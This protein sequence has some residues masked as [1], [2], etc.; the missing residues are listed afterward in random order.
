MHVTVSSSDC[1]GPW[2]TQSWNYFWMVYADKTSIFSKWT[3][4]L[5]HKQ[6]KSCLAQHLIAYKTA[7]N[8]LFSEMGKN[9]ECCH[10][11]LRHYLCMRF[12]SADSNRMQ[13]CMQQ[14]CFSVS[15][16]INEVFQWVSKAAWEWAP[17]MHGAD[18]V[19]EKRLNLTCTAL[20]ICFDSSSEDSP[21]RPKEVNQPLGF[22]P[23]E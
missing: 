12:S 13:I 17:F 7:I 6:M 4:S 18:W 9:Y 3:V 11:I 5:K 1:L 22:E 15:Q 2:L 10:L 14:K 8:I 19:Q 16:Y 23:F 20:L 21:G